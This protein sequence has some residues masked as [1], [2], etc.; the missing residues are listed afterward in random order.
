MDALNQ[1]IKKFYDASTPVWLDTWGE[2]MHHGYYGDH[3][4]KNHQQA[5]L[6]LVKELL[7]WGG[8]EQA[9][10]VLD[11]G[12]GVGGSARLLAQKLGARRVLGCTLSSVQAERAARYN[13]QAG[14]QDKVTIVARDMMTL[15]KEDGPFDLIWSLESAEHI[16]DKAG[17]LAMFYELLEPGGRLLLATWC[18]RETPPA[19]AHA[20]HR[21]LEKLQR[22]YHLPP[23]VPLSHL[24]QYAS[25]AGFQ[26]VKTEDW[27]EAV[28]PF[29]KAVIQSALRLQSIKGLMQAGWPTIKGAWAMRQMTKGYKR[30]LIKFGVLQAMKT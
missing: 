30:G 4:E 7:R 18:H 16:A 29:W 14:L 25:Q 26:A 13:E 24:R 8:V 9:Q 12:C 10:S 19:L 20:D 22:L 2:H 1:Q 23:F 5:Q 3:L 11:A 27:S 21:V 15:G 17:L 6:D 28:A